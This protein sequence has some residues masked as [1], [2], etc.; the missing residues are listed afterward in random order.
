MTTQISIADDFSRY[1]VGRY[2]TDGP[3]SGERF[4]DEILVP[5]LKLGQAVVDFDGG[6]GYGSSFLEE[7][8]GGLVRLKI[9][10]DEDFQERL[11]LKSS[12]ESLC[13][14]VRSYIDDELVRSK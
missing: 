8:F 9:F 6:R 7:A 10:P 4:R 13:A 14:E 11:V 3:Y 2:L 1:P 12:N 5:A